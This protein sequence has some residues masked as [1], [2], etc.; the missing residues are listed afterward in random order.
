[1]TLVEASGHILGT[2]H[3]KI[4]D[5]VEKI[6]KNRDIKVITKI[7]VKEVRDN[8]AILSNG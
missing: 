7:S 6:F 3:N 8:V 1:V 5:Y 2:F 4:V